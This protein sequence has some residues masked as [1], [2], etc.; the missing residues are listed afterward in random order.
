MVLLKKGVKTMKPRITRNNDIR[1][2]AKTAGVYLWEIANKLEVSE[3][4]FLRRL[5]LE[6]EPEYKGR[7]YQ[8]ISELKKEAV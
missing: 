5:R 6:M 3:Q 8:V 4:T 7:I 1:E 2:A